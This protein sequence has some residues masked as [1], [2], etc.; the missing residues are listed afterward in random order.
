MLNPNP[1]QRQISSTIFLYTYTAL[2]TKAT[3]M[4]S[5]F[6]ITSGKVEK[7]HLPKSKTLNGDDIKNS[8]TRGTG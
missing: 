5:H 3:H 8:H 6:L 4:K 1:L 2:S 7:T